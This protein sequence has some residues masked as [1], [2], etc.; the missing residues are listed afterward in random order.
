MESASETVS[1]PPANRWILNLEQVGFA[2]WCHEPQRDQC[3]R[4]YADGMDA[5]FDQVRAQVAAERE[6]ARS[7]EIRTDAE[8]RPLYQRFEERVDRVFRIASAASEGLLEYD[9]R[10]AAGGFAHI[11]R[12]GV[13]RN[14][15]THVGLFFN[16]DP[17][18]ARA[19]F[20][21]HESTSRALSEGG[22]FNVPLLLISDVD[23]YVQAKVLDLCHWIDVPEKQ[24]S[25]Y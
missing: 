4:R 2:V 7:A 9:K 20:Q 13:R 24:G 14:H 10:R 19:W 11:Y 17:V 15:Y 25:Q 8:L 21:V 23:A 1:C 12:L 16:I 22:W 5:F 18:A 3:G 6:R